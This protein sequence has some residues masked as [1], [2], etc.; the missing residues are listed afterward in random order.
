MEELIGWECSCVFSLP[1][2]DWPI[3]GYPAWIVVLGVDGNM[4]KIASKWGNIEESAFWCNT[5]IIT[6]IQKSIKWEA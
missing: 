3:A 4:I 5:S 6:K 2:T 1:S